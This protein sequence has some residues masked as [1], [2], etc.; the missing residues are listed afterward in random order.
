MIRAPRIPNID[1]DVH[2]IGAPAVQAVGDAIQDAAID[3]VAVA[4]LATVAEKAGWKDV[5]TKQ[6]SEGVALVRGAQTV[7]KTVLAG[8]AAVSAASGLT[9]A[10]TSGA[11]IASGL[12]AAG[13]LVGGG[14]A[15]GPAVL[16]GGPA[17]LATKGLNATVFKD[18]KGLATEEKCARS[19]ARKATSL[20]A[21][22]GI[23]GVGAATVAG[24]ASGAAIMGTLAA[25]G[26]V[27]GMGA[28]AGA[29]ILAV[30]PAAVAAGAGF[31]VYK[32]VRR[33]G[34]EKAAR[35]AGGEIDDPEPH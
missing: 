4:A 19:A 33:K 28:I 12:A 3:A 31:G 21:T 23:V 18:E 8:G 29:A 10:A 25:V 15:V 11:G 30:A 35:R 14:M 5:R 6:L 7:G 17:Y 27:I 2:S 32:F 16:A 13:G 1:I 20:G 24:G 22:A 34:K 26:G 9:V